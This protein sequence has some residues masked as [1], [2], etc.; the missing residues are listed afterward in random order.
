MADN[1]TVRFKWRIRP[2]ENG[3]KT[4]LITLIN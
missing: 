3:Y 4:L 1:R 2:R